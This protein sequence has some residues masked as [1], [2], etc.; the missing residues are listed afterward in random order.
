L[1][2]GK[3][4]RTKRAITSHT[5][6]LAG[7]SRVFSEVLKAHRAIEVNDLDEMTEVL[8]VCQGKN[9]PKGPRVSVVTGSGGLRELIL[10]NATAAGID[11]PPLRPEERVEAERVIGHITGDGNPLDAWGN[12]NYAENCRHAFKVLDAS[13]QIDAVV[14]CNDVA[15]KQQFGQPD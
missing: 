8:A 3:S 6:G 15:D 5:G 10:D 13:D 12:G 9:W 2:V 11:M 4:E 7:E 1:K 14:Y